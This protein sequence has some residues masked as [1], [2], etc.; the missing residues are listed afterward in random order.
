MRGET[1]VVLLCGMF[2][3]SLA[4]CGCIEDH[5]RSL[6]RI[7]DI[8]L[9]PES[10]TSTE[11]ALNVTAYVENR[12]DDC[13]GDVKLLLKA[14]DSSSGLLA[15]Q[16]T[17]SAGTILKERTKPVSQSIN[18][19]REG[20]YRIDAVL[21]EDEE[22]V[23][24]KMVKIDG[25]GD[26]D[27]NIYDIGVRVQ[28]MDFL[29]KNVTDFRV[30]IGVD[31]YL[32]NEGKFTSEDLP[33]LIKARESDAGLLADKIWTSTGAVESGTTIIRSC[34]IA[35]PD[36]YNYIVE[37]LIWKND[38]IV[39]RGDGVVQLNPKRV[40]AKDAQVISDN[41]HTEDFVPEE[42]AAEWDEYRA[43]SA[44]V[45]KKTPGFTSVLTL[46]CVVIAIMVVAAMRSRRRDDND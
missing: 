20:G 12:G 17:T 42:E 7:A 18:V 37:V 24:K 22:I 21:F 14:F 8:D 40:I 15:D 16:T 44:G 43:L 30:T 19:K 1:R 25:I 6:L 10:V 33:M 2:I 11:V 41:V 38:T 28:E 13:S 36:N 3:I 29:V 34:D 27:P 23:D 35:V 39:E 9:S 4:A 32:T 31:V 5:D 46:V 26:L 45:P